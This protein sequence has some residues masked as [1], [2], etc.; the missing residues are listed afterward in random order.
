L[1]F[2]SKRE[3][4]IHHNNVERLCKEEKDALI[5][6]ISSFQGAID[7]II[8]HFSLKPE[9]IEKCDD[10]AKLS[11]DLDEAN[12]KLLDTEYFREVLGE[13]LC[14]SMVYNNEGTS[15]EVKKA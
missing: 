6:L 15:L 5:L 9:T 1:K 13:Q 12:S 2:K 14:K 7:G 4:L 3:K 8:K 10:Y 11:V